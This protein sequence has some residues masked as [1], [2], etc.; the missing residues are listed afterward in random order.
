MQPFTVTRFV[1]KPY[2][3]EPHV[4]SDMLEAERAARRAAKRFGRA[5]L[6]RVEGEPVTNLW[7]LPALLGE[8][9]G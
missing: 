8:Y 3:P 2:D 1:V 7:R 5:R 6:Y 9:G 4:F